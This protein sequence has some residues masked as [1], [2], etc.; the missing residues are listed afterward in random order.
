[1]RWSG[2]CRVPSVTE[3]EM[4]AEIERLRL[5]QRALWDQIRANRIKQLQ[6][7]KEYERK[8][9]DTFWARKREGER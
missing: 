2:R 5:S 6:L 4:E 1:M 3:A 8:F 7:Q 9:T